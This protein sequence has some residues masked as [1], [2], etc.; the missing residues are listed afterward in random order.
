MAVVIQVPRSYL[1]HWHSTTWCTG[2]S[3]P[4]IS[5]P[6]SWELVFDSTAHD[7]SPASNTLQ[8]LQQAIQE[9]S[10]VLCA[11]IG[12]GVRDTDIQGLRLYYLELSAQSVLCP[13]ELRY[14]TG[15]PQTNI[16]TAED[17]RDS[18]WKSI[19]I[20]VIKNVTYWHHGR[21]SDEIDEDVAAIMV[22]LQTTLRTFSAKNGA[23]LKTWLSTVCRNHCYNNRRKPRPEVVPIIDD[24]FASSLLEVEARDAAL[25]VAKLLAMLAP[26]DAYIV[27]ER[28]QD[29]TFEELAEQLNLPLSTVYHRWKQIV[30]Q[31]RRMA[32]Y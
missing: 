21:G 24:T 1:M 30:N 22:R 4:V 17:F 28:A 29:A 18:F 2:P 11:G 16:L 20:E 25:D 8:S 26:E 5:K 31:L 32:T 13:I 15:D 14:T 23:S 3:A 19:R 12:T 10:R 7:I 27:R 6:C 9:L